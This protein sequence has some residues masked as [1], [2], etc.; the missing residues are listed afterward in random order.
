MK[1]ILIKKLQNLLMI[2]QFINDKKTL[3]IIDDTL[4]E[5]K[6]LDTRS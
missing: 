2:S 6:A 5:I 1:N 4:K 3:Q